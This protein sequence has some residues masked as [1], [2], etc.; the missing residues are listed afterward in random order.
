[1]GSDSPP[2]PHIEGGLARVHELLHLGIL[3]ATLLGAAS[4]LLLLL[5]PLVSDS[6]LPP[7]TRWAMLGLVGVAALLFLVEW[8][9]V[10]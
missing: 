7:A 9:V 4:L 3:L 10:H 2:E 8:R 5:W 6:P 1:M